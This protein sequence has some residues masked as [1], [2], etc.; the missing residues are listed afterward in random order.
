MKTKWKT[1]FL[2]VALKIALEWKQ[3]FLECHIYY[4][5]RV[6]YLDRRSQMPHFA[7]PWI[8]CLNQQHFFYKI[9]VISPFAKK[10]T[11]KNWICVSFFFGLL[12]FDCS[13]ESKIQVPQ[14]LETLIPWIWL[15]QS[16]ELL[17]DRCNAKN[18]R[19]W[20]KWSVQYYTMDRIL[21][22]EHLECYTIQWF[23]LLSVNLN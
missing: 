18:F 23:M 8:G 21:K 11:W 14:E 2:L 19:E 9:V 20:M 4:S 1:L 10:K 6:P 17:L 16:I 7:R 22:R 12:P 5:I 15:A 13:V 3:L